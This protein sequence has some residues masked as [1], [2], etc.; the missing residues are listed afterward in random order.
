MTTRQGR[1][2]RFVRIVALVIVVSMVAVF[3]AVLIAGTGR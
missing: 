1:R 3:A 2:E